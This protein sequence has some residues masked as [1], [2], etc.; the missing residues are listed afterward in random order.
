[1]DA[2]HHARL[3][4]EFCAANPCEDWD[5][6]FAQAEMAFAAPLVGDAV[7]HRRHY[8]LAQQRGHAIKDQ[9]DRDIFLA[10]FARIPAPV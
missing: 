4:L 8:A 1:M 3:A 5:L 2:L 7:V 9:E 10:E 6:A